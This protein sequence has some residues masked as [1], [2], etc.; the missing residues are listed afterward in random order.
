MK[1]HVYILPLLALLL[2]GCLDPY[3]RKPS[4]PMGTYKALNKFM[5]AHHFVKK[6]EI[7]GPLKSS[8]IYTWEDKNA[9]LI[10]KDQK[11]Q[12]MALVNADGEII[13]IGCVFAQR[14]K[15]QEL[16]DTVE[17][18]AGEY[19][20]LTEQENPILGKA[21][22]EKDIITQQENKGEDE[23]EVYESIWIV[24]DGRYHVL[25]NK[26]QKEWNLLGRKKFIGITPPPPKPVKKKKKKKKSSSEW[27]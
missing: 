15:G 12:V 13:A 8:K 25:V 27:D 10:N 1:L 2:S 17:R 9:S 6:E 18:M 5:K 20:T 4:T 7:E 22:L 14:E 11:D 3:G 16:I 19:W 21:P 26:P 24:K 23:K